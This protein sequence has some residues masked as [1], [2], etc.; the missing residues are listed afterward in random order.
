MK[1]LVRNARGKIVEDAEEKRD[2]LIVT[3]K[4]K[5]FFKKDDIA[6]N[7]CLNIPCQKLHIY[8]SSFQ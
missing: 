8:V 5:I 2:S 7:F 4:V 6:Y 1:F 3:F